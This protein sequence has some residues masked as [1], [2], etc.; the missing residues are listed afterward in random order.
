MIS[1][2]KILR[3]TFA[4]RSLL[5]LHIDDA[6]VPIVAGEHVKS[7]AVLNAYRLIEPATRHSRPSHSTATCYGRHAIAVLLAEAAEVLARA[8][9]LDG[10]PGKPILE[11]LARWK[12]AR[13][14]ETGPIGAETVQI[15]AFAPEKGG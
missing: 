10:N 4:Q 12:A 3:L 7:R 9:Y 2:H 8:G 6:L 1:N 5:M 13:E 14:A 11:T 15:G